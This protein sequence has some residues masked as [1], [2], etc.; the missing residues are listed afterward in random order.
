MKNIKNIV[1]GIAVASLLVG[2]AV[3]LP[4]AAKADNNGSD[5]NSL[6]VNA[7]ASVKA[8]G[9][10]LLKLDSS[11]GAVI[12]ANGSVRV[13]GAKVVSVSGSQISA[14]SAFGNSALNFVV[15]TDAN[16]KLNGSNS[17][18]SSLK[19]GDNIS[20]SGTMSSSTSSSIVVAA[21][22][23][24]SRAFIGSPEV[25]TNFEG[26]ITAVNTADSS[27]SLKLR[28]GV[29]VKVVSPAGIAITLDGS[30]SSL[31]SLSVG[32]EAKI[33]GTL[34]SDGTVI[35]ASKIAVSSNTRV[36]DE[37]GKGDGENGGG[38]SG[39]KDANRGWFGNM[40]NWLRK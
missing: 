30:A 14:T 35:T 13:L 4:V 26:Q 31:A 19:A 6:F 40:I 22:H 21:D 28:S 34:S 27:F 39:N 9:L 37:G 29:T 17:A 3:V 24:V 12:G 11:T 36:G 1:K 15:N 7:Q 32:Q 23:L 18:V 16:T 2:M 20:F 38:N 5:S 8:A 10:G 25:K 33:T